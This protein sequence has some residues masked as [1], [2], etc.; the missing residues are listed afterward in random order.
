MQ[1]SAT[2]LLETIIREELH[3]LLEQQLPE[4]TS[5]SIQKFLKVPVDGVFGDKTAIAVA[6]YIYGNNHSVKTVSDLY[7]RM[8]KDGMSVGAK[9]GTIFANN[10][11]MAKSI[12]KLMKQKIETDANSNT[13]TKKPFTIDKRG[14]RVFEIP[15]NKQGEPIH[16]RKV[17]DMVYLW[18][19]FIG[20]YVYAAYSKYPTAVP[21]GYILDRSEWEKDSDGGNYLGINY[22]NSANK[23]IDVLDTEFKLAERWFSSLR[24][25]KTNAIKILQTLGKITD[26]QVLYTVWGNQIVGND[27]V[28]ALTSWGKYLTQGMNS[29]F[30]EFD[31]PNAQRDKKQAIE[32]ILGWINV[33]TTVG[34]KGQGAAA[35][36]NYKK[37]LSYAKKWL[38]KTI[39][40]PLDIDW[41]AM[42]PFGG[43]ITPAEFFSMPD[44]V[45]EIIQYVLYAFGPAGRVAS[46]IIAA[47]RAYNAYK[48]GDK[49]NAGLIVIMQA[50][51]GLSDLAIK[52]IGMVT[53]SAR[54]K[55]ISKLSSGTPL[56]ATEQLIVGQTV[57]TIGKTQINQH[58]VN[59]TKRQIITALKNGVVKNN[60]YALMIAG[61]LHSGILSLASIAKAASR[62]IA[63]IGV[64]SIIE[65]N[66]TQLWTYIFQE[67]GLDKQVENEQAM[68]Q[69]KQGTEEFKKA[70]ESGQ[71]TF[72]DYELSADD[73]GLEN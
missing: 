31:G 52:G 21:S 9:T 71:L 32:A 33:L 43:T 68:R 70:V 20:E 41:R 39:D 24:A 17:N 66:A 35:T 49:Y 27:Q 65:A 2:R 6:N 3:F 55:I 44:E 16:Q 23:V 72:N 34:T 36:N 30:V 37:E 7:D 69:M 12:I 4:P 15:T 57:K 73:L 64:F 42:E 46:W 67:T 26:E 53:K 60:K 59:E 14:N 29:N 28:N 13:S 58:L 63:A 50:S 38:K 8:K 11:E 54:A 62:F 61:A 22:G 18:N 51:F 19:K 10:G 45:Q 56:T 47:G 48:Q 1:T 40:A 5:G 25:T